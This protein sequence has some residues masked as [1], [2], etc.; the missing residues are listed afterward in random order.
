MGVSLAKKDIGEMGEKEREGTC[1][2]TSH[3]MHI[4]LIGSALLY[5]VGCAQ[6][7]SYE[8]NHTLATAV[9]IYYLIYDTSPHDLS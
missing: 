9:V 4:P 3:A 5:W 1:T 7:A 2:T 6:A 8:E